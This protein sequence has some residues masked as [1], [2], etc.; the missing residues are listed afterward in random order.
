MTQNILL[1]L[2]L[3]TANLPCLSGRI[4]FI[5]QP[6]S[7]PKSI[8]WCLLELFVYYGV[9]IALA[10]YVEYATLGG[11]ATQAWEFYA[12]TTSLFLVL[13]FPGFVYKMLWK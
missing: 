8:A 6:K 3:V 11:G 1:V 13:A 7:P 10:S 4:F 12:V 9:F 2:M 5:F